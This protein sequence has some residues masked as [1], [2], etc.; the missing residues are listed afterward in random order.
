MKG[1]FLPVCTGKAEIQAQRLQSPDKNKKRTVIKDGILK[2]EIQFG[3]KILFST[4]MRMSGNCQRT[5]RV[6]SK[7]LRKKTDW[8]R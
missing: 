2:A 6:Q 4:G 8:E 7:T 1:I 3:G 5:Y